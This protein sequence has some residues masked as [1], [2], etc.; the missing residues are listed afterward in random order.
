MDIFLLY[1]G[2]LKNYIKNCGDKRVTT[3]EYILINEIN[4]SIEQAEYLRT[5]IVVYL[6]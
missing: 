5:P 1:Y 4:D 6:S 3:I 2:L